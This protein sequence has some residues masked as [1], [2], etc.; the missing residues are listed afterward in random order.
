[1]VST[2]VVGTNTYQLQTSAD[3][4]LADNIATGAWAFLS[5]DTKAQ[6]LITAF[7]MLETQAWNGEKTSDSQTAQHP[8]TGLTNCNGD[9]IDSATIAPD[10]IRAQALLAFELSQDPTLAGSANTGSN[11]KKLQAGAASIEYFERTDDDDY[12]TS[13]FPSR[14]QE[15]LA[16]YLK[17]GSFTGTTESFG[18]GVD[19][20]FDDSYGRNN[21]L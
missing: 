5:A 4:I 13:R 11:I 10:I 21:P 3:T 19:S 6:A 1:M 12:P 20:I 2:L 17:S 9:E 16:C 18:T 7:N 15:L 8:R 14:V